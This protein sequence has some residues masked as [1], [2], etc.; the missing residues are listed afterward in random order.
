MR[1]RSLKRWGVAATTALVTALVSALVHWLGLPELAGWP[2][3]PNGPSLGR[4]EATLRGRVTAVA[5][6][7]TLTLQSAGQ[8]HRVRLG[9]ID[10][11]ELAQPHGPQARA[12]LA[13]QCLGRQAEV[14]THERDRYGRTVGTVRCGGWLNQP[15]THGGTRANTSASAT[16]A[17]TPETAP[18]AATSTAATPTANAELVRQGHAWVY[19]RYN[20]DP[21]LPD[22]QARARRQHLGLW[23]QKNPTPPWTWRQKNNAEK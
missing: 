5:D 6:G 20:Q 4:P 19:E 16:P 1:Q 22:L 9:G 14:H 21:T 12:A 18:E 13:L 7:D 23:A 15:S 2:N 10:A 17:A 3:L 8:E 11:P